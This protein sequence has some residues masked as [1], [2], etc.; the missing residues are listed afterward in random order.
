MNDAT[1]NVFGGNILLRTQ[2]MAFNGH[3][4]TYQSGEGYKTFHMNFEDVKFSY[5]DG[6]TATTFL[7]AFGEGSAV[8]DKKVGY[9]VSFTDCVFDFEKL[10]SL[11]LVM[12]A[13]DNKITATDGSASINSIV[14]V[15]VIG[16][17]IITSGANVDFYETIDNGSSVVF[18]KNANKNYTV[19]KISGNEISKVTNG[20]LTADGITSVFTRG[21]VSGE[22]VKYVI[23]PAVIDEYSVKTSI[24]LWSNFVY[25]IYL[26][27]TDTL[28]SVNVDGTAYDVATL[29]TSNI[30]GVDYYLVK[31][32]LSA[33]ESLRD[34]LLVLTL[35]TDGKSVRYSATLNVVKYSKSIL[36]GD[37]SAEEKAVVSDMLSYARA[38]YVYFETEDAEKLALVNEILGENYD[39]DN[40]PELNG[41]AVAPSVGLKSV[42]YILNA[43]PTIRFRITGNADSYAFYVDGAKLNTV[44]GSDENGTYIDMDVYAYAMCKTITY[45]IDGVESGSYHINCYYTFVKTDEAHKDNAALINLVA[46]FAKYCESAAAY[47]DS[48]VNTPECEH[49]FVNGECTK[50][51]DAEPGYEPEDYGTMSLTAPTVIYSNYPAKALNVSFSKE[52]YNGEITYTT[53]N[54]NVFVEDGKIYATGTFDSEV[55]VTVTAKTA[56]HEATATVKVSTYNG[57]ISAEKKIQYY[58]ANVIKE[59]NK[60]GMIFVGD[61]YVDGYTMEAPPFWRD[62]YRDFAG[63]K[64]FLMGLS[65][66][67]IHQ[68]EI[69]SE[70]IV[71]PM[72]PSEIVVN[73]GHNDLHHGSL[74]VDQFVE[75]L[76][77]LFNEYHTKLPE[78]KIYFFSV[79]PKKIAETNADRYVSSFEKAPAANAAIKAL[80]DTYD[81]LYFVDTTDIFYSNGEN[82]VNSNMFPT[83]DNSHPSL[84]AYDL[85]KIALNEVRGVEQKHVSHLD[86]L[87]AI[88]FKD[89][90]GNDL[91]GDF[92][93]SGKLAITQ[94]VKNNAHIHFR[95]HQGYRFVF[96]D[97]SNDGVF[98][99]GYLGGGT[100]SDKTAGVALYDANEGIAINW[101]VIT[102]DGKA[103]WYINGQLVQTFNSYTPEYFLIGGS[104]VNSIIYDVELDVR[105]E[106]ETA[107]NEHV[108]RYS[109]SVV[110]LE[111]YGYIPITNKVFTDASGNALTDNYIIKGKLDITDFPKDNVYIQFVLRSGYR[112]L[113]W[114]SNND[115]KF[116]AGY[117]ENNSHTSDTAAGIKLYNA[118]GGLTLDWAV[119]V[120]NS[121][122]SFYINGE[123]IKRL[124]ADSFTEFKIG[125]SQMDVMFSDIELYVMAEDQAAYDAEHVK[126]ADFTIDNVNS[127]DSTN[128][129]NTGKNLTDAS[130]NALTNN[131]IAKGTLTITDVALAQAHLQFRFGQNCRFLLWDATSDGVFGAGYMYGSSASDKTDGVN[132]YDANGGLTLEWA[133]VMNEGVA[134]WYLNGELVQKMENPKLEMLNI[135]ALKMNVAFYNTKVYTKAEDAGVYATE[136][137][138]F[139]GKVI[140][141]NMYGNSSDITGNGHTFTYIDSE[142]NEQ[143]L[144]ENYVIRGKL[145]ISKLNKSNAHVQF[146]FNSKNRFLIWDSNSDGMVGVGYCDE[147]T[148]KNEV[149]LGSTLYDATGSLTFD[150]AIVM[151]NGVAYWYLNGE[152]AHTFNFPTNKPTWFN[153]GV[154]Q[155]NIAI[156]DIELYVKAVSPDEYSSVV[157]EYL[158]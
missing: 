53:D 60:G 16:G 145:N 62:F 48:V 73:I 5:Y 33:K 149:N 63:E 35:N 14:N 55:S 57:G 27:K 42:T 21:T 118:N 36:G 45:T 13:N 117:T 81:W 116:G 61:S 138:K 20:V 9:D 41:S 95:F 24:S 136:L 85:M 97:Q 39:A 69:A 51:G 106:N 90:S 156:Y 80:A 101:T 8:Y 52:D 12:N 37:H 124:E 143:S 103:Y 56:H 152:L 76:T 123:F 150:F 78:A 112:F 142:N 4:T 67:Q 121:A 66:S 113:L 38:A 93:I 129:T 104:N 126:Y 50:C 49:N 72:E 157:A 107:Y 34:I 10:S 153:I 68:L 26:L 70:R 111:T 146:S 114:D 102:K 23:M 87:S 17:E 86:T 64:A 154:L 31:V 158:G 135:G 133:I 59:E 140:E 110:N 15:R 2:L 1:F 120:N 28:A 32:D 84:I 122:A 100:V 127:T 19:L 47:R 96:W 141:I 108:A 82:L 18:E 119:V 131:Y 77:A 89:A 74:T 151:D 44:V 11:A 91:T 30:G 92:A 137:A 105:T 79:A 99:A 25:N 88:R 148:Y 128:I 147:G 130:G 132:L 22:Y 6:A 109:D 7:G 3:G 94:L 125:A 71:Y 98:G 75:R 54:A 65:S 134:Y 144:T 40:T 115:G 29:P 83:N 46:R 58:E 155:A 43:T 139:S